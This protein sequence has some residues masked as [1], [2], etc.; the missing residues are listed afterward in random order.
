MIRGDVPQPPNA[1]L[2]KR[3]L[4]LHDTVTLGDVRVGE[5]CYLPFEMEWAIFRSGSPTWE[6]DYLTFYGWL[7]PVGDPEI[8]PS[9]LREPVPFTPVLATQHG[10]IW[11]SSELMV[12]AI[13]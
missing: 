5:L 13:D 9:V 3:A 10:V 6:R 1:L 8:F 12:Y 7:I 2:V 11:L 4:R